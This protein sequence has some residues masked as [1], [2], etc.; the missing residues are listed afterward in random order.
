MSFIPGF[1]ALGAKV[2]DITHARGLARALV[3]VGVVF[4]VALGLMSAVDLPATRW[5]SLVLQLLAY[6]A[7]YWLLAGFYRGPGERLSFTDA[8]FNRF[9]PAAGLNA[10]AVVY[11]YLNRGQV[12]RAS[13]DPVSL[14][15]GV[16]GWLTGLAGLYLFV[17]A[18]LLVVRGV[19]AAG[20]D[21]LAGAYVYHSDE[22]RRIDD[23]VYALVRHPLYAGVDRLAL[24]FGLWSGSAFGLL[25]AVLFIA[26]WHPI[27]L[28][29]EEREL[30]GRFGDDY[31]RYRETVPALLPK[32]LPAGELALL[33]ILTR[34]SLAKS[35]DA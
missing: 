32:G 18:V 28:G 16:V 35:A 17:T 8:F 13:G 24:A 11:I 1:A 5:L 4:G 9:L 30:E 34:R 10:A 25:L 27:W 29:L 14:F 20:V 6:G 26:V 22:G 23:D 3:T 21:T 7:T 33:E 12:V 31:R 2:P 15:P 19:R